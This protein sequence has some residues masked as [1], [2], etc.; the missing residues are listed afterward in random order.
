MKLYIPIQSLTVFEIPDEFVVSTDY[1][2]PIKPGNLLMR[3]RTCSSQLLLWLH[4][5]VVHCD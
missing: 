3:T 2:P 4:G 5:L 1:G